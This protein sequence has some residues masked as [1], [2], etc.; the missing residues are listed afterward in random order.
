MEVIGIF[1]SFKG[2]KCR[3]RYTG[4]TRGLKINV[5]VYIVR[6]NFAQMLTGRQQNLFNHLL[7]LKSQLHVSYFLKCPCVSDITSWLLGRVCIIYCIIITDF[8]FLY[9]QELK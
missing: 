5:L 1:N 4:S 3:G 2:G 7:T 9:L 6:M 8:S